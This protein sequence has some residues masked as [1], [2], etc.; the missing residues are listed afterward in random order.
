MFKHYKNI[1]KLLFSTVSERSQSDA[2]HKIRPPDI[3]NKRGSYLS[4]AVPNL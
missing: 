3:E 1:Y 4:S 2:L